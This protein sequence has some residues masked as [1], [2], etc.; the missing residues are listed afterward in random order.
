[1][2]HGT[3]VLHFVLVSLDKIRESDA[4]LI[5]HREIRDSPGSILVRKAIVRRQRLY[6]RVSPFAR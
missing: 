5:S 6:A 2:R 4:K 1:M 3:L